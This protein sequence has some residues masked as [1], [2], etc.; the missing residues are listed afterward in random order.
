M[1]HTWVYC[2][3]STIY[4]CAHGTDLASSVQVA[5]TIQLMFGHQHVQTAILI[6]YLVNIVPSKCRVSRL[7]IGITEPKQCMQLLAQS[8]LFSGE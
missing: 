8:L 4:N 3:Y 1:R 2:I 6:Q 7:V 5:D